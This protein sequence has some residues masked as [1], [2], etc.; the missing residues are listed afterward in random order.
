MSE[1][2]KHL[3]HLLDKKELMVMARYR[4]QF[5]DSEKLSYEERMLQLMKVYD[6]FLPN[7]LTYSVYETLYF[8]LVRS[9]QRK[10]KMFA[11]KGMPYISGGHNSLDV[12]V[13]TGT[14]GIGKTTTIKRCIEIIGND[15]IEI[16]SS[17]YSKVVPFIFVEAVSTNSFKSFLLNILSELD[18]C[19]GTS[20]FKANNSS[21]VYVDALM[22]AVSRT[23]SISCGVII[24]DEIDRF[25]TGSKSM[26]MINFLTQLINQAGVSVIFTGTEY[27]RELFSRT[28]YL[29]RRSFGDDFR[30]FEYDE[31]Y[32][33]FMKELFEY[34]YTNNKAILTPQ[35]AKL[36]YKYTG[37]VLALLITLFYNAQKCTLEA[38][39]DEFDEEMVNYAFDKKMRPYCPYLKNEKIMHP[40]INNNNSS[41]EVILKRLNGE[42]KEGVFKEAAR[43]SNKDPDKFI[44]IISGDINVEVIEC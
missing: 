9:F 1:L 13:I 33:N 21:N 40:K 41:D 35:I 44:E 5:I 15:V 7:E 3:P 20:L 10:E 14:S 16:K 25:V 27:S 22:N 23:L 29:C 36:F 2:L 42:I 18:R 39:R 30:P 19:L 38:H 17:H 11:N 31:Q 12:S 28:R 37:G 24:I 6:L 26:T 8:A 34:Q 4:P 43:L 32:L